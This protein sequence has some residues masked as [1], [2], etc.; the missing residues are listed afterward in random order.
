MEHHVGLVTE[1]RFE[2]IVVR[3]KPESRVVFDSGT[4]AKHRKHRPASLPTAG[5]FRARFLP[6]ST[7]VARQ[8]TLALLKLCLHLLTERLGVMIP[9]RVQPFGSV[10]GV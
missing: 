10:D 3:L 6:C 4:P 1:E 7:K 9:F 8:D 5:P 2:K